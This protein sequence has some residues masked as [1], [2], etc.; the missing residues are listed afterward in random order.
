MAQLSATIPA[1]KFKGFGVV[2]PPGGITET[3]ADELRT[4]RR[5]RLANGEIQM[6]DA[7]ARS[8]E[9]RGFAVE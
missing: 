2:I 4:Q 9:S 1:P 7:I 8:L 6:A 5:E 3:Y